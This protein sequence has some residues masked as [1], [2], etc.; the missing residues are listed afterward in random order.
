[1]TINTGYGPCA[2]TLWGTTEGAIE[3]WRRP[4]IKQQTGESHR[5]TSRTRATFT[6]IRHKWL[7]R[8]TKQQWHHKLLSHIKERNLIHLHCPR[9]TA[10]AEDV[11]DL[12][13]PTAVAMSDTSMPQGQPFSL[14]LLQNV[15][16]FAGDPD[17]R[18]VKELTQKSHGDI[19]RSCQLQVSSH[20]RS[21]LMQMRA[22]S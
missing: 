4:H 22:H 11:A 10:A 13:A 5:S 16:G 9:N 7:E 6:D 2:D 21:P 3:R 18:I 20:S 8:A 1:M 17:I 12:L 19:M 15:A 14:P